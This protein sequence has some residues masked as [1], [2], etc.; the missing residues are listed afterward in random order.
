LPDRVVELSVAAL[1]GQAVERIHEERSLSSL[2][3]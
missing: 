2:F 3:V 1:L